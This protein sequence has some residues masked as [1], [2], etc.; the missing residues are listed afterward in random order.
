MRTSSAT[1]GVGAALCRIK[2]TSECVNG[3]ITTVH[4][5]ATGPT[6]GVGLDAGFEI[7][8]T[9]VADNL[10]Y[11]DPNVFNG[12]FAITSIGASFGVGYGAATI[13][14]GGDIYYNKWGATGAGFGSSLGFGAGATTVRG[15]STV[16]SVTK[17]PCGCVE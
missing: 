17:E 13:G 11:V 1:A 3:F 4:I 10:D 16:T 12:T 8:T 7:S 6:L 15:S 2:L 9:E 5:V 14:L